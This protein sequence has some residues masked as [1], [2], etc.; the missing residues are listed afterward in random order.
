MPSPTLAFLVAFSDA[1]GLLVTS[2]GYT[3][4]SIPKM[5]ELGMGVCGGKEVGTHLHLAKCAGSERVV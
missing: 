4:N 3:R 5:L 1:K 2:Q